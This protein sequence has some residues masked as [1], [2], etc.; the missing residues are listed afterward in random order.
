M[1][2]KLK[3]LTSELEALRERVVKGVREVEALELRMY[4]A[5]ADM[6]VSDGDLSPATRKVLDQFDERPITEADELKGRVGLPPSVFQLTIDKLIASGELRTIQVPVINSARYTRDAIETKTLILWNRDPDKINADLLPVIQTQFKA[7][8]GANTARNS[9]RDALIETF[10]SHLGVGPSSAPGITKQI[11][12]HIERYFKE[13]DSEADG[14][15]GDISGNHGSGGQRG[16][17]EGPR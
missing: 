6:L 11:A 17:G 16:V 1:T 3:K 4:T 9:D 14:P 15:A 13:N 10:V 7:V 8:L 5:I 2:A 12:E